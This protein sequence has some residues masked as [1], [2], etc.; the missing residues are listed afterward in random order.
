M[1]LAEGVC[2]LQ[3]KHVARHV[4]LSLQEEEEEKTY[5]GHADTINLPLWLVLP[6]VA[7]LMSW[8][9]HQV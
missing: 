5:S 2:G 3:N 1:W 8:N 4:P 9:W 6:V 7:L